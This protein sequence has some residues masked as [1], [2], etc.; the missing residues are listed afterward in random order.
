VC[1]GLRDGRLGARTSH[2]AKQRPDRHAHSAAPTD[3]GIQPSVRY[4]GAA[5][6]H[7]HPNH[8]TLRSS[9]RTLARPTN[10]T[11][12]SELP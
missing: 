6:G 9:K 4:N 5:H 11:E 2:N 8:E 10:P 12:R 3:S 1:A 7:C